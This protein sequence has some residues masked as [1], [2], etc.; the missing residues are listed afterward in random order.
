MEG[1]DTNTSQGDKAPVLLSNLSL[2]SSSAKAAKKYREESSDRRTALDEVTP[3]GRLDGQD[4][5]ASRSGE[6][7][8]SSYDGVVE[9]AIPIRP[10]DAFQLSSS[11]K[12]AKTS[13]EGN[14][15]RREALGRLEGRHQG[16][17]TD[18]GASTGRSSYDATAHTAITIKPTDAFQLSSSAKAAKKSRQEQAERRRDQEVD[19]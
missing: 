16:E 10:E 17:G 12:A 15:S 14:I 13:R 9:T 3:V 11:A 18:L 7:I 6:G 4:S 19:E 8:G 2:L 1:E 5:R